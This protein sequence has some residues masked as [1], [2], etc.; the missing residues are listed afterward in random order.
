LIGARRG[1]LEARLLQLAEHLQLPA[2]GELGQSSKPFLEA[3]VATQPT[4]RLGDHPLPI[5]GVRDTAQRPLQGQLLFGG[6]LSLAR[7]KSG[8]GQTDL[9]TGPTG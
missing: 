7:C 3:L 6:A 2:V 5:R 8:L 4:P 9:D 1:L